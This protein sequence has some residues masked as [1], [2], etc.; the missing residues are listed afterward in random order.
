MTPLSTFD[1]IKEPL[2]DLLRDIDSGTIQLIDF[3]RSWCWDEPR[4]K[5]IIASVSLGYPIGAVML[6]KQGNSQMKFKYR[7]V[8]GMCEP[9]LLPPMGLLTDGQQRMT[10]LWMSL[11]SQQPVLINRGKRYNP[12]QK[13]FYLDI[14]KALNYPQ[15]PRVD[16]IIGLKA[17][18]KLRFLGKPT[19]DCSSP[20]KEFELDLFP[21]SKVFEFIEWRR[22]YCKYWKYNS[23]NMKRIEEF[24]LKVIKQFEHY[25]MGVFILKSSLPQEAVC[26]IFIDNNQ[27]QKELTVFDLL[28]ASFAAENFDLRSHWKAMERRFQSYKLLRLLKAEDF[29]QSIALIDSY[30][31]RQEAI[32]K[33]CPTDQ[34]PGVS[35]SRNRILRLTCQQYQSW[36]KLIAKALEDV[37]QFLHGQ[38][39]FDADDLPYPM[40]LVVMAPVFVILGEGIRVDSVR[41]LLLQWFYCGAASGIYSRSRESQAA[42][43]LIEFPTW[44]QGG[45]TPATVKE[46]HLTAE[47]LQNFTNSQGSTYRAISALLRR[48]G[49]LDFLS[50]EQITAALYFSGEIENH[51][52]FPQKW[53][54]TH[55][56]DRNR[57]NSIVNKTPLKLKTNKFLGGKAP[58][59][60]L[61]KLEEEGMSKKRINEILV[62]HLIEPETLWADDFDAFFESRT[63]A[64]LNLMKKAMGKSS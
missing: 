1:L 46:S 59:E 20:E 12:E 49:A 13:Y 24:E 52:I 42:K 53:C 14:K 31:Q 58:S 32:K 43:D 8:E 9:D 6:L 27:G 62:S 25:Q 39:I 41:T 4:V 5:K 55:K 61:K 10:S 38:T 57:C 56:I 35:M 44:V 28:A 30:T 18:K 64:L 19:L 11:L 16:A 2:L 3:Q 54:E 36:E 21:V 7:P 50:G 34:L 23:Q 26:D 29:L 37:A 33:G 48:D 17:N 51:H 60:Y 15:I 22:K 45:E 47:R 63:H 40:H